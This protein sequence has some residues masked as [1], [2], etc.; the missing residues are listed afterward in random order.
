MAIYNI[1]D[2]I[3]GA[4]T[5]YFV[6]REINRRIDNKKNGIENSNYPIE[7]VGEVPLTPRIVEREDRRRANVQPSLKEYNPQDPDNWGHC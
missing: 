2:I 1:R 3:E 6:N 4:V 5:V 7:A